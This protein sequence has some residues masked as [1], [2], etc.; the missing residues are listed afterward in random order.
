MKDAYHDTGVLAELFD[1]QP[2]AVCWL[3]P[4]Y[5][6]DG[7]AVTDFAFT[8]CN[9]EGLRYLNLDR[10]TQQGLLLSKTAT[11]T[12]ELRQ[13]FFN[14]MLYVLQTGEKV[15]TNV[16]NPALNKWAKILRT[17]M[18][19]GVLTVVQDRTEE[20]RIIKQL[21][22]QKNLL[23][24]ILQHSPAGISVIEVIRDAQ[25]KVVDGRTILA[26]EP[27]LEYSGISKDDYLLKTVQELDP[28]MIHS[29]L[30]QMIRDTLETGKPFF[31]QYYFAPGHRWLELSV[32]KMDNDHLINVFMDVTATKEAQLRQQKL[33][34]E[35]QRS[36]QNL[37]EFAYAASHDLKEPIRKVLFSPTGSSTASMN[38]LAPTTCA[39]LANWKRPTTVWVRWLTICWLIRR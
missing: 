37:E 35:L 4:V 23:D 34:D 17:R 36:N 6:G 26:N 21:E 3:T 10:A 13:R 30:F 8:Y 38:A 12:E 31:T 2:Q 7:T 14:E 15:K 22:A 5:D 32:A 25:G 18:R 9:E 29:P 28:G 11:V 19:N 39:C 33:L 20:N 1:A 24:S 16:Y 27:A